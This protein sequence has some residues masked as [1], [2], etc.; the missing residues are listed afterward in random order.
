FFQASTGFFHTN[1][2]PKPLIN[3]YYAKDGPDGYITDKWQLLPSYLTQLGFLPEIMGMTKKGVDMGVEEASAGLEKGKNVGGGV[4]ALI[5]NF[6][7]EGIDARGYHV[8]ETHMLTVDEKNNVLGKQKLNVED[9]TSSNW[10]CK[11]G[12]LSYRFITPQLVET[13][14]YVGYSNGYDRY[15]GTMVYRYFEIQKDGSIKLMETDRFFAFTKYTKVEA[16]HFQACCTKGVEPLDD[17][18]SGEKG[19]GNYIVTEHLS[20]EDLDVMRNEIFA[21]YGYK[22]KTEKWQ[23]YFADQKW[24]QPRFDNVDDKLTDL[25]RK[26]IE[27]ILKM[28]KEMEGKEDSYT[29]PRREWHVEAG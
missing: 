10:M 12:D 25:D 7:E 8:E 13:S 28:K 9:Y 15:S 6:M 23:K 17:S 5:A 22:F 14:G 27:A 11:N 20:I 3:C 4:S 1:S 2:D 29:Q 16:R 24:Y 26:N 21:E 18:W 19:D